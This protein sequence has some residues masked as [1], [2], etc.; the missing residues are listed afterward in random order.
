MLLMLLTAC[1][2]MSTELQI[3]TERIVAGVDLNQLFALP[4][5]QERQQVQHE[6]AA[7]D[8]SARDVQEVARASLQLDSVSVTLRIWHH[9]VG[10]QRHVGAVVM[11]E[12]VQ[13]AL[14]VL[15][16]LHG[17]NGGVRLETD[18]WPLA[19]SLDLSRF[20][21]VIPAF[22]GEALVYQGVMGWGCG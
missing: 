7:R 6:W 14:P 10:G 11:P 4:M 22:R 3:E 15:V 5:F 21:L 9:T 17:G 18:V 12:E 16:W 8:V 19:D 20:V 1:G 2:E 13:E